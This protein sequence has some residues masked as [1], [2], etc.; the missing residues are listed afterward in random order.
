[1]FAKCLGL[2]HQTHLTYGNISY[3]TDNTLKC[4]R[5]I[6]RLYGNNYTVPVP[7]MIKEHCIYQLRN[8]INCHNVTVNPKFDFDLKIFCYIHCAAMQYLQMSYLSDVSTHDELSC[9]MMRL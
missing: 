7:F 3:F 5:L 9:E 1:M 4:I 2:A 6:Y 8:V